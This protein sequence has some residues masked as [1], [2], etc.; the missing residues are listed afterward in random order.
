MERNVI[1]L[2]VN[3]IISWTLLLVFTDYKQLKRNVW[4]GVTAY[5]MGVVVDYVAYGAGLYTVHLFNLKGLIPLLI[6]K[7]VMPLPIGIL[8][9][10]YMP[11]TRIKQLFSIILLDIAYTAIE[12]FLIAFGTLTSQH[13]NIYVS[14]V[15]NVFIFATLT[16]VN[17]TFINA[18]KYRT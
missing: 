12:I 5:V 13:W 8:Y 3:T 9:A 18:D 1:P 7:F 4:L 15:Y 6:G 2:I 16:Y 14:I 10:Q 11:K 17:E